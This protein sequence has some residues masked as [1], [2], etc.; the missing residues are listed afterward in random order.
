MSAAANGT[1][2]CAR[3]AGRTRANAAAHAVQPTTAHAFNN[4]LHPGVCT[5]PYTL[6]HM[7]EKK[8]QPEAAMLSACPT[9]EMVRPTKVV[10]RWKP[11]ASRMTEATATVMAAAK[12][13]KEIASLASDA[14]TISTTDPAAV[15]AATDTISTTTF[16]LLKA[17]GE[18][19]VST[20][21]VSFGMVTLSWTCMTN[22][23]FWGTS[24]GRVSA[25]VLKMS[26][27]TMSAAMPRRGF[28]TSTAR[29]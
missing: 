17:S 9:S 6:C 4:G 12:L 13:R 11:S 18:A 29:V 8:L 2:V 27:E 22:G 20:G 21:M 15:S 16:P 14:N 26:A 23:D 19:V 7:A 28:M 1:D 10:R 25:A 24:K 3:E 5:A